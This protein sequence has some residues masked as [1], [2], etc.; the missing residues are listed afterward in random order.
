MALRKPAP[1]NETAVIAPAHSQEPMALCEKLVVPGAYESFF[2]ELRN[3]IEPDGK[4]RIDGLA[5]AETHLNSIRRSYK[6][7]VDDDVHSIPLIDSSGRR[8]NWLAELV[9][10]DAQLCNLS[11]AQFVALV[12][13]YLDQVNHAL[14][15]TPN[16]QERRLAAT[17]ADAYSQLDPAHPSPTRRSVLGRRFDPGLVPPDPSEDSANRWKRA[18]ARHTEPSGPF[19][20]PLDVEFDDDFSIVDWYLTRFVREDDSAPA[21]RLHKAT[22]DLLSQDLLFAGWER[23]PP[24]T[25]FF[26]S[27]EHLAWMRVVEAA[28]DLSSNGLTDDEW[29]VCW[30][31]A[32]QIR[33]NQRLGEIRRLRPVEMAIAT[34]DEHIHRASL[35]LRVALAFVR[36]VWPQLFA[37]IASAIYEYIADVRVRTE[38]WLANHSEG[39]VYTAATERQAMDTNSYVPPSRFGRESTLWLEGR[40][41]RYLPRF[42]DSGEPSDA[43]C[44]ELTDKYWSEICERLRSQRV[45]L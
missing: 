6:R 13:D 36:D 32:N 8:A 22:A 10:R 21:A 15:K 2:E 17:M 45:S 40:T 25:R 4:I 12:L 14:T 38:I 20:T 16:D 23:F 34:R 18:M 43:L 35:G 42:G 30:L 39:M 24:G 37:G 44:R 28:I 41:Y 19:L 11:V 5:L 9:A 33:M 31:D 29:L 7:L 27:D 1:A 3:H 26:D